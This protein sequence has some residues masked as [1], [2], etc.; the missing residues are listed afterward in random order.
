MSLTRITGAALLC[1]GAAATAAPLANPLTHPLA[2]PAMSRDSLLPAAEAFSLLPVE[3]SGATLHLRWNIAPGYYLYRHRIRVEAL[4]PST[5][6]LRAIQLPDGTVHADENF[7][8]VETY[9]GVLD[10]D[11]PLSAAL[12]APLKLRVTYQGCADAGVC[13]PPQ[14]VVQT[15]AP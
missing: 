11:V 9:R 12:A 5:V 14:T 7:G 10:A 1:A 13:Y 3:D 6:G 8:T 2:T 4:A 15:I